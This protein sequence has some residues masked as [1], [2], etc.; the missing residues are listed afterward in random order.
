MKIFK[1]EKGFTLVELIFIVPLVAVIFLVSYNLIF[2]SLN[3]FGFVN[4]S[5]NTSEDV[6]IF[7]NEIKKE[8]NEA[9][10]A[11]ED[12]NIGPIYRENE[13]ELHIYTTTNEGKPK[14]I[15]Y[16]LENDKLK[17]YEKEAT[18]D[19]YPYEFENTFKKEKVVLS[20]II[21][22][23][24]FGEVESLKEI[25]NLQEGE[26]HRVKVKMTI[27]IDTGKDTAPIKIDTYLVSKSRSK[28]E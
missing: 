9:K 18:N 1:W 19:S 5:F 17:K 22:D 11:V 14:L 27:K 15:I 21:N 20:N 12:E 8:A 26:D 2:I 25:Q 6:R 4:S 28:F 7:L 24:I 16:K 10:K 3:S 23:D 13:Q